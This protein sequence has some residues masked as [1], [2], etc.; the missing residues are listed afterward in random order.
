MVIIII[1]T[2]DVNTTPTTI[3]ESF[4]RKYY[5]TSFVSISVHAHKFTGIVFMRF[6]STERGWYLSLNES[7]FA[8]KFFD[9]ANHCN[10]IIHI[11]NNILLFF[12]KK[13]KTKR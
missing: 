9:R 4:N 8:E 2:Y 13:N 10:V 6:D 7:I 5:D 11:D 12:S 1:W 3:I